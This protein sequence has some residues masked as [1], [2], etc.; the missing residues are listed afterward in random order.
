MDYLV[1][2]EEDAELLRLSCSVVFR[3]KG[4]NPRHLQIRLQTWEWKKRAMP[5]V[6][7]LPSPYSVPGKKKYN[8]LHWNFLYEEVLGYTFKDTPGELL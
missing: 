6:P 3:S 8:I 4:V 2:L 7:R 5:F 1:D